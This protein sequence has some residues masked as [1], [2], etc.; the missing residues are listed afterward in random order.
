MTYEEIVKHF[1]EFGEHVHIQGSQLDTVALHVVPVAWF[2]AMKSAGR[3]YMGKF[4]GKENRLVG[5]ENLPFEGDP[6]L[7][8]RARGKRA[9]GAAFTN[10]QS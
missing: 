4:E 3:L 6:A 1:I 9:R 2:V 7:Y 8:Q 10:A 5:T